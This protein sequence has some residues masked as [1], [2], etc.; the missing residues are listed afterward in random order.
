MRSRFV[1]HCVGEVADG[2]T[3]VVMQ[4]GYIPVT[5]P[6]PFPPLRA[7]A[8]QEDTPLLGPAIDP[9]GWHALEPVKVRGKLFNDRTVEVDCTVSFISTHAYCDS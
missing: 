2:C 7:M 4:F 1:C 3:R 9:E 5:F 6:P 8:Y